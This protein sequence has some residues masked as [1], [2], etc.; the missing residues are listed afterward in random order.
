MVLRRCSIKPL[1]RACEGVVLDLHVACTVMRSR[2][3]EVVLETTVPLMRCLGRGLWR[4]AV[5]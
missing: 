3:C 2:S 1:A 5:E 4:A